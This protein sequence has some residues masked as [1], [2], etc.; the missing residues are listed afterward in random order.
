MKKSIGLLSVCFLAAGSSLA[1]NIFWQVNAG[2]D[3]WTNTA[4]WASGILPGSVTAD[5]AIIS[6]GTTETT[7]T[8]INT[9]LTF[10]KAVKLAIRNES[11]VL[12]ESGGS[13]T[14]A[15]GIQVGANGTAGTKA[16]LTQTG[17]T[18]SGTTLEIGT[19]AAAGGEYLMSGSSVLSLTG[20]AT[21]GTAG[22]L[23]L[24]GSDVSVTLGGGLSLNGGELVFGAGAAGASTI[25]VTGGT[26]TIDSVNSLLSVDATG[27]T[28][29]TYDLVTFTTLNGA[30]DTDNITLTGLDSGLSGLITY[31]DNSMSLT[32]IPE[33][34]TIGLL[35]FG[36]LII[37][38]IRKQQRI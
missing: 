34:A 38:L 36:A 19:D 17:G 30:F 22:A 7:A 18:L 37:L 5:T 23:S 8:T 9:A 31:A 35:G 21:F 32:V 6:L 3:N 2:S 20:A 29:G 4:N 27:L 33:P 25:D 16:H 28:A 14:F 12:M 24:T 1:G 13:A 10:T 11:Y 26:F 15:S